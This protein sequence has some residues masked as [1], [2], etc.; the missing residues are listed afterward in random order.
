MLQ[1]SRLTK[2]WLKIFKCSRS[3]VFLYM[4]ALELLFEWIC[5]QYN[6]MAECSDKTE[7]KYFQNF[8]VNEKTEMF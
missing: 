1:S 6:I 8:F 3:H 5:K 2:Q 7:R 4:S